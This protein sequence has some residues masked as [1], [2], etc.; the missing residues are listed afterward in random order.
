MVRRDEQVKILK[1]EL[2]AK[3]VY[4]SSDPVSFEQLKTD[5]RTLNVTLLFEYIGGELPAQIFSFM[6]RGSEMVVISNLTGQSVPINTGDLLFND[7]RISSFFLP[8][9]V[10][11]SSEETVKKGHK[12]L[13]DDLASG[14]KIFGSHIVKEMTLSQFKEAIEE[15]EKIATEGKILIS[16]H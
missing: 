4:N 15:S 10:E 12:E 8:I 5:I 11:S 2:G 9:W 16:T 13:A 7:K 6:P 14:G 3:Y 1:E